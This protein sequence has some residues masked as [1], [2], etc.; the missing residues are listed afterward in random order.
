MLENTVL[1]RTDVLNKVNDLDNNAVGILKRKI[2]HEHD[3][4][5]GVPAISLAIDFASATVKNE[6]WWIYK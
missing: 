4:S 1:S 2:Q 3:K 6:S 5:C